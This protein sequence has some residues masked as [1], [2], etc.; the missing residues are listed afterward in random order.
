MNFKFAIFLVVAAS[1]CATLGVLWV[2]AATHA[3]FVSALPA[4]GFA[5]VG[6]L[7]FMGGGFWVN[8]RFPVSDK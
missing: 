3:E 1:M 2:S 7:V 8:V 6:A 4:Y 5:W